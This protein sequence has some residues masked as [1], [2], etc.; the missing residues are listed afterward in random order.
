M[1]TSQD[2]AWESTLNSGIKTYEDE[3]AWTA[4]QA[5]MF[6]STSPIRTVFSAPH[7]ARN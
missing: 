5:Y 1:Q 3:E 2:A 6:F 7:A 4:S